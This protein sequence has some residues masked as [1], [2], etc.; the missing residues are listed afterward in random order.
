M[1]KTYAQDLQGLELKDVKALFQELLKIAT[2]AVSS[3]MTLVDP[4]DPMYAELTSMQAR[5]RAI[6]GA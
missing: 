3:M 6:G 1:Q 4:D 5:I 2:G